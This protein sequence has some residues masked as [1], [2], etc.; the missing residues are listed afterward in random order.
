MWGIIATL[1]L[2]GLLGSFG[3]C[4]GMCGPLVILAGSRFPQRGLSSLPYHLLYNL[5]KAMMYAVLGVLAGG[6]GALAFRAAGSGWLFAAVSLL[7]GAAVLLSGTAYLGWLRLGKTSHLAV[8]WGRGVRLLSNLSGAQR[9]AALGALN[10]LLPCGLVYSALLISAASGSVATGAVGMF[11]FGLGTSLS[12]LV[13]G[14]GAGLITQHTRR[15]MARVSGVFILLV[16]IQLILRGL[17]GLG[18]MPHSPFM[19]VMFW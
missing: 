8:L 13:V 1:G 7:G 15:I 9:A 17:A 18:I 4:V 11:V 12:L 14:A 3:H 5:S 2:T 16:G 19:A 6:A 10:G